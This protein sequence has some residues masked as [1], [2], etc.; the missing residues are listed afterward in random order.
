MVLWDSGGNQEYRH[1]GMKSWHRKNVFLPSLAWSLDLIDAQ[2]RAKL[3]FC[4]SSWFV[5]ICDDRG[6]ECQA[7][8]NEGRHRNYTY[9][10]RHRNSSHE[11]QGND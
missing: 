6:S 8:V 11:K 9:R 5:V 2:Q 4:L 3:L 10:N 1:G 7:D